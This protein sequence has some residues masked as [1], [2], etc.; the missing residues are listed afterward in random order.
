MRSHGSVNHFRFALAVAVTTL[1][2]L[3]VGCSRAEEKYSRSLEMGRKHLEGKDYARAIIHFQN[4][5]QASPKQAEPHY[6]MATAY[7]NQVRLR[8]AVLELRKATELKPDYGEAQLKLAELMIGTRNEQLIKDAGTRIQNVLTENPNDNDA[9]FLLAA[10]QMQ[11][12]E[13]A[14]AEKSLQGLLQKSPQHFRSSIA[15]AK[16]RVSSKDYASAEKILKKALELAPHSS[17][18]TASAAI[19]YMQMDKP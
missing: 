9:L 13:P 5:I 14:D 10:T 18:A 19:L 7:L 4:A 6:L 2:F 15:L 3:T 11:L 16:I 1:L 8:E 12:G 17:D